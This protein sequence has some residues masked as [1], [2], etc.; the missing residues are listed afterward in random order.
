M[1]VPGQCEEWVLDLDDGVLLD[2]QWFYPMIRYPETPTKRSLQTVGQ[3]RMVDYLCGLF[4]APDLGHF[5]S[6]QKRKIHNNKTLPLELSTVFNQ[7]YI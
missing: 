4:P 7:L 3:T 1:Q 6:T 5:T 2:G